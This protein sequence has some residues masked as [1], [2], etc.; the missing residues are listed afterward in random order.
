LNPNFSKF[1]NKVQSVC[2]QTILKIF[3]SLN[4]GIENMRDLIR[5]NFDIFLK[6]SDIEVQERSTTTIKLIQLHEEFFQT[7]KDIS[8]ELKAIFLEELNPVAKISQE[9]VPI[10]EGLDLDK[11]IN[12][13]ENFQKEKE[14]EFNFQPNEYEQEQNNKPKI[15][16]NKDDFILS[17][18]KYNK[19]VQIKKCK[20]HT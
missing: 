15:M 6:S 3:S 4:E 20:G 12:S 19:E 5:K 17:K 14:E 11:W 1:N 18:Q 9:S 13:E 10:P 8:N 7:E 16:G 2:V